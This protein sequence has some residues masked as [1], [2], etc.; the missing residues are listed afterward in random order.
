MLLLPPTPPEFCEMLPRPVHRMHSRCNSIGGNSVSLR[1]QHWSCQNESSTSTIR[2]SESPVV[3]VRASV[4]AQ[5]SSRPNHWG[6]ITGWTFI[7]DMICDRS[8]EAN[9]SASEIDLLMVRL[10]PLSSQRH[11]SNQSSSHKEDPMFDQAAAASAAAVPSL[12]LRFGRR[13]CRAEIC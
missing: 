5:K 4:G 8:L 11:R 2:N 10:Q 9:S 1:R 7:Q 13:Q 3:R 6:P 12:D